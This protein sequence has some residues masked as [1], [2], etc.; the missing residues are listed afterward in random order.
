MARQQHEYITAPLLWWSLLLLICIAASITVIFVNPLIVI[1]AIIV[2]LNAFLILKYPMYGLVAYLAIFLLRP[3]ELFPSLAAL[4]LELLVGGFALLATIINQKFTIG[5]VIWPM[6]KITLC[7]LGLMIVIALSIFTSYEVSQTIE[8]TM[9]FLKL[10][11]FYYLI[12]CNL[13]T[14]KRF[15]TFM[16][17]FV[18]LISYIAFDAFKNYLGGAFVHTMDVDRLSGSTSAGGDPNTLASTMAAT[19]PLIVAMFFYYRQFFAKWATALLTIIMIAFITLTASRGGLVSFLGTVF[20]AI[21]YSKQKYLYTLATVGFLF[22]G[23]FMLPEQYKAR[24]ERFGEVATDINKGSSG[25]WEIWQAGIQMMIHRPVLG[26]GAGA[27]AWAYNSGE[28]GSP[29]WMDPH[30]LYIQVIASTGALGTAMWIT[31]L[32]Y[33]IRTLRRIIRE[34]KGNEETGWIGTF[35]NG[36]FISMIALFVSGMFGHTFFRYTWYM[37]AGL[38]TALSAMLHAHDQIAAS[39][40]KPSTNETTPSTAHA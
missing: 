9:D 10:I 19:V 20:A 6:D 28:F 4:R 34:T 29:Q 25:R 31:F 24:Y 30:N 35:A 32:Y 17:I 12:V 23:W 15:V 38:T 3:A 16:S 22:I 36:I 26:V 14:R 37:M 13:V 11:I 1:A 21:S 27:F 7:M 18:L 33:Y 40:E 39:D 5:R 2:L 8:A